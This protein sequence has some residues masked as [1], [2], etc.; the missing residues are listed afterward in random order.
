VLGRGQSF[1]L[2]L[3]SGLPVGQFAMAIGNCVIAKLNRAIIEE[4]K[5]IVRQSPEVRELIKFLKKF[6]WFA[7]MRD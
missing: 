1:G 3:K 6:K 7:K 5:A 2:D 4:F